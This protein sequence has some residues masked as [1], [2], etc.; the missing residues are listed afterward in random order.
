MESTPNAPLSIIKEKPPRA[1]EWFLAE[2]EGF[3]L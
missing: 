3:E 1:A 2:K